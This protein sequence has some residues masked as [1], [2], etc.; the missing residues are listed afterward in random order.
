[1]NNKL[2]ITNTEARKIFQ[3]NNV[4]YAIIPNP[5]YIHPPYEIVP[6]A[7]KIKL[8]PSILKA[9]V[10]DMD[11]TIT[12]TEELCIHS[13]EYMIRKISGKP[14]YKSWRGL[15]HK[16]DYPFII[17]NSTTKHVEYLIRTYQNLIGKD[18]L[19][20]SYFY[21]VVWTLSAGKDRKRKEEVL[22]NFRNF[23]FSEDLN[24]R[25]SSDKECELKA[26]ELFRKYNSGFPL[27]F[28]SIVKAGIDIYYQRYHEILSALKNNI[29]IPQHHLLPAASKNL[30]E[31]MPGA[32]FF[33]AFIKG[34][35]GIEAGNLSRYFLAEYEKKSDG[36]PLKVKPELLIKRLSSLSSYFTKNP[37]KTSVVTSSIFYE[38]DIVMTQVF[39][40]F[41]EQ[42]TCWDISDDRK[43][44][45][46]SRFSSYK[47]YFDSFVTASDS[48][49]IRL[50]PH[51][52][53]YSIA[54]HNL[55]LKAED[56]DKVI[57]F[58]D[59]ESGTLAIRAAGIGLCAA[60]PFA[61]TSGHNLKASSVILKGGLP[62]AII[63]YNLF[64]KDEIR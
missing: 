14:D 31:P 39:N 34:L 6:L 2:I 57:G 47:K 64:L 22:T 29:Q 10:M 19:V 51:R 50:K 11:G 3:Q 37:V 28:N 33:L 12:T 20:R 58:E 35:L 13:L 56:F 55:G 60:V 32:A 4:E 25:F 36:V 49:E 27:D 38:A 23:G 45:I 24:S 46:L 41:K 54:L 9:V 48:S 40:L 62:E 16:K 17:G 7:P 44:K 8:L 1:M 63:K 42:I 15:D 5:G 52:D 53:L 26:D 59:S 43:K 18:S 30:I 21:A 61:K